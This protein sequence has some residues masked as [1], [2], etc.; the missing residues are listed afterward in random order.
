MSLITKVEF[1]N[2]SDKCKMPS[3]SSIDMHDFLT[4]NADWDDVYWDFY[5]KELLKY[6]KIIEGIINSS[7]K[8]IV[9]QAL[10]AGEKP[11]ETIELSV[12]DFLTLVKIN[13]IKTTARYVARKME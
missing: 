3:K 7:S 12:S 8:G 6:S 1:I 5:P 9:F 13:K 10:W 2:A 4:D 11:T